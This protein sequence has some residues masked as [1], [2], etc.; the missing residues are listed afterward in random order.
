MYGVL[1]RSL[2]YSL[3]FLCERTR[4]YPRF[5][6]GFSAFPDVVGLTWPVR[7]E[8]LSQRDRDP[9]MVSFVLRKER[10]GGGGGGGVEQRKSNWSNDLHKL[11][12]AAENR[13]YQLLK[14]VKE[15]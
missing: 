6:A 7:R 15:T 14:T 1:R 5:A 10:R 13:E 12:G 9:S 3:P 8:E 4:A 11:S 2:R